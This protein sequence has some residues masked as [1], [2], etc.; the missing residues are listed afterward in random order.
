[1]AMIIFDEKNISSKLAE[2]LVMMVIWGSEH[3]KKK[4]EHTLPH[5]PD[6]PRM[7]REKPRAN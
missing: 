3:D 5:K 4:L 6:H 1:V 2:N 7:P